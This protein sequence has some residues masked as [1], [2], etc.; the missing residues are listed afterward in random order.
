MQE[1]PEADWK[2]LTSRK[3][4]FLHILRILNHYYEMRGQTR[5][6]LYSFR[7]KLVESPP[8]S[9]TIYLAKIGPYEYFVRGSLER[10]FEAS[11]SWIHI[12]GIAEERDKFRD[13]GNLEHPVFSITCLGDLF[14]S[15][16]IHRPPRSEGKKKVAKG[17]KSI[18]I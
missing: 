5:N 14:E 17:R 12:D 11:E 6:D 4:E 7:Q 8:D 15:A 16:T 3:D 1:L 2:E 9:I 18:K 13:L 10:N